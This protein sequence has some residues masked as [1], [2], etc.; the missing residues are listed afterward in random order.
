MDDRDLLVRAL[1]DVWA[2]LPGLVGDDWP[3]FEATVL[4]R[5]R[6]LEAASPKE[7]E[8]A[9]DAVLAEFDVHP[10]ARER[11]VEAYADVAPTLE[12]GSADRPRVAGSTG[13]ARYLEIP[14][15]FATDRAL[16][17]D[18]SALPFYSGER[19]PKHLTY[20]IARVS[21]PDD[22]RSGALE[23]P[24]WWKLQF[25]QDPEQFVIVLGVDAL[26]RAAFVKSARQLIT[27]AML[28]E[29]LVFI[30]GYNVSFDDAARRAAQIVVRPAL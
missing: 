27:T 26:D 15:F 4:I 3:L 21:V 7:V 22:H 17:A 8:K 11:L 6:A 29:A 16:A 10:A 28:P 12:R 18:A 9:C 14:V 1:V 13:H 2:A 30:H 19:N 24:S 5:L 25:R 23:K 20:G